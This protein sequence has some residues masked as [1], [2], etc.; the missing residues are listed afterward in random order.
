MKNEIIVW[1]DKDN[2]EVEIIRDEDNTESVGI[3]P[4]EE[5][6]LEKVAELLEKHEELFFDEEAHEMTKA[7]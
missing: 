5:M 7:S 3:Y 4:T 1:V 6:A 2:C